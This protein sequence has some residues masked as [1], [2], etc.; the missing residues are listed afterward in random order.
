MKRKWLLFTGLILFVV[1]A[2]WAYYQYQMPVK[3]VSEIEAN[4]TM[5][6]EEI[7]KEFIRDEAAAS[8]KYIGKVL[9]ISGTVQEVQA[10]DNSS[11]ILLFAGSEPGGINCSF[12]NN[13]VEM[14]VKGQAIIVKG[15][16][17]GF[18]MDVNLTRTVVVQS[19]F[20]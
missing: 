14:P 20:K 6:A 16:C 8:E 11:V 17:T 13:D 18:L 9:K 19:R 2:V 15:V 1:F 10:T 4:Y 3:N 5:M 12:T 7:Y